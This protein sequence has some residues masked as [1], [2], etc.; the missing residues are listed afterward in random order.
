[1]NRNVMSGALILVHDMSVCGLISI[2]VMVVH[3]FT[4]F[5]LLVGHE[6]ENFVSKN[7]TLV[8]SK[9][10]VEDMESDR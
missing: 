8:I 4:A 3:A 7:T 9:G 10:F 6:K 1:M 5:T 2:C